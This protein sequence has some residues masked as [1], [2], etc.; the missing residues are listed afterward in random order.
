MTL[1]GRLTL[2]L[3]GALLAAL[4]PLGLF[5]AREARR[6][7]LD[8]LQTSALSRLGFYRAVTPGDLSALSA[9]AQEL[10]GYGFL[11]ENGKRSF[12][13]TAPHTLPPAVS[14]ALTSGSSYSG[15]HAGELMLVIPTDEGAVGLA[16]QAGEVAGLA[17]RLLFVYALAAAVLLTLVGLV[18][19]W[20]LSAA[21]RPLER[22]SGAIAAR[23]PDNLS[24][25]P[26]P[27]VSELRPV[28]GRLN[29]LLATLGGALERSR[30]QEQ[31]ARRFAAQASHELRTPLTA[32]RGYLEVLQRAPQEERAEKGVWRET[33]R[34]QRLLDALLL[35]TRLEGRARADTEVVDLPTFVAARFPDLLVWG[36]A[37][38]WAE[39]GLLELALRNLLTNAQRYGVPP[40][41]VVLEPIGEKCWLWFE[42]GGTGFSDEIAAGAFEPFVHGDNQGTGLGLALVRAV[43][44]VH[45]GAVQLGRHR[46][47]TR[48]GLSFSLTSASPPSGFREAR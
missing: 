25:F 12:T 19:R 42:D 44:Q 48:V 38:V 41:C 37:C 17:R 21:L 43:A 2:L 1:R 33:E 10:G 32:L 9:L 18:G 22:L 39:P 28:V 46:Q 5:T 30:T 29:E 34:L 47:R 3:V 27:G 6:V 14:A 31:A 40:L 13:D 15:L 11:E 4:L 7:A 24:A 8:T 23:S 36:T 35:L 26:E 16:L 45:G 20:A